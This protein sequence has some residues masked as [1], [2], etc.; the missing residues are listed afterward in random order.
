MLPTLG[1]VLATLALLLGA[2]ACIQAD[3]QRPR[4][5]DLLSSSR[6]R[7][8]SVSIASTNEDP[9]GYEAYGIETKEICLQEIAQKYCG[10]I[11][12]P[13]APATTY[14]WT[15]DFACCQEEHGYGYGSSTGGLRN[16]QLWG[17]QSAIGSCDWTWSV[18]ANAAGTSA[19]I[20]VSGNIDK[21]G[22]AWAT[23]YFG[24]EADTCGGPLCDRFVLSL[25]GTVYRADTAYSYW[26]ASLTD[27]D[28]A[29]PGGLTALVP[30]GTEPRIA[31]ARTRKGSRPARSARISRQPAELQYDTYGHG[32]HMEDRD[33]YSGEAVIIMGIVTSMAG[34]KKD[35]WD[36]GVFEYV[37]YFDPAAQPVTTGLDGSIPWVRDKTY[38]LTF[39]K[40]GNKY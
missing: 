3:N 17:A 25:Q 36:E 19:S 30:N 31:D 1:R 6:R 16:N 27:A 26:G 13:P 10:P 14:W 15:S 28:C 21:V 18:A 12:S 39:Y 20:L 37:L 29:N 2:L 40:Q 32:D 33:V 22:T 35:K 5:A 9:Y 8:A 34:Q 23:C 11:T 7:P 38:K 24:P 4:L